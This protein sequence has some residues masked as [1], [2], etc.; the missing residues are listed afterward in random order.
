MMRMKT[1][2]PEL[3]VVV[4]QVQQLRKGTMVKMDV[5]SGCQNIPV[6]R[7]DRHLLGMK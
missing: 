6:H 5:K 7:K 3:C 4:S 1:D 2:L